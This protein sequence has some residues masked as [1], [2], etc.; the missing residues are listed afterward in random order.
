MPWKARA[1]T[2]DARVVTGYLR[3]VLENRYSCLVGDESREALISDE[4]NR[5]MSALN[6]RGKVV[7]GKDRLFMI[8]Y[9][10]GWPLVTHYPISQKMSIGSLKIPVESDKIY[11]VYVCPTFYGGLKIRHWQ[12]L[13]EGEISSIQ[14]HEQRYTH[15][16]SKMPGEAE[17]MLIG[18]KGSSINVYNLSPGQDLLL[19]YTDVIDSARISGMG[20]HAIPM[21]FSQI[22]F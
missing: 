3:Q 5:R 15:Y 8:C 17:F 16:G 10:D 11:F 6:D 21:K 4:I 19:K 22:V 2:E 13:P 1:D 7:V 20:E 18:E 9:P 14:A 12:I